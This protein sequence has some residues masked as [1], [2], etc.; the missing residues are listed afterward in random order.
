MKRWMIWTPLIAACGVEPTVALDEAALRGKVECKEAKDYGSKETPR[1]LSS[2]FDEACEVV[3]VELSPPTTAE[4][5]INGK[6]VADEACGIPVKL[7][8]GDPVGVM[9]TTTS[10][11]SLNQHLKM[12]MG[13]GG[14]D[15]PSGYDTNI[16]IYGNGE[17]CNTFYITM[18]SG[19]VTVNE[20]RFAAAHYTWGQA[21]PTHY[22]HAHFRLQP[23][24]GVVQP[25]YADFWMWSPIDNY[26]PGQWPTNANLSGPS[27]NSDPFLEHG[28]KVD[29][30]R[31]IDINA[32][33]GSK[34]PWEDVDT[35][36]CTGGGVPGTGN[37]P[38]MD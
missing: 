25:G 26:D 7:Q 30:G 4:W 31:A 33:H 2:C 36:W 6:P 37:L 11:Y 29:P 17:D 3:W 32:M 13:R 23:Y 38:R 10:G 35:F 14:N 34:G 24:P 15:D 22:E 1:L 20:V 27:T 28:F 21:Y 19:C 9:A 18:I 8:V 5:S 16:I 12:V